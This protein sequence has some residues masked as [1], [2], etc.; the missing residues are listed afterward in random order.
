MEGKQQV[1][2]APNATATKYGK[3]EKEKHKTETS[4]ATSA[5]NATTDSANRQSYQQKHTIKKAVKYA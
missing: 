3:T 4:N 2:N 5:E 1:D